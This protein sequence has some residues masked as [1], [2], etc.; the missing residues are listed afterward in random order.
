MQLLLAKDLNEA[1]IEYYNDFL[2]YEAYAQYKGWS[3]SFTTK[4][5]D[6]GRKVNRNI[7]LIKELYK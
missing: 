7:E 6:C 1:Y 4:V 5:I 3:L 2:T